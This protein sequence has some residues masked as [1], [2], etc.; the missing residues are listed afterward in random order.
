MPTT[1][2]IFLIIA[3][4]GTLGGLCYYLLSLW[5]AMRFARAADHAPK[6]AAFTPPISILKPLRGLDPQMMASFRSHCLQDYPEYEI[7]F[8]VGGAGMSGAGMSGASVSDTQ[9]DAATLEAVA[10]LQREFPEHAIRVVICDEVLGA[11]RKV[12]TL[13]QMLPHARY[14]HLLINDS[15]IRVD[16]DYLRRVFAPFDEISAGVATAPVGMVTTLYRGIAGNSLWAKVESLGISTDFAG[17]VLAAQMLEGGLRFGLGSTLAFTKAGLATIG[18]L[19]PIADYLGDDY[20]LG[21]RLHRAGY[22]IVLADAVVDTFLPHYSFAAFWQHQMR[23]ARNVRDVRRWGYLGVLLT[24]GLPWAILTFLTS[25][26]TPWM[27]A[28]GMLLGAVG[29]VRLMLAIALG[30]G[31][32]GDRQV[33]SLLWLVPLRDALAML[34][35]FASF[36]GNTIVWRGM[37]YRLKRGKLTAV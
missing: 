35:W 9:T 30:I 14:E 8:G 19:E 26:G 22:R 17:G 7:I 4:A 10:Q 2:A 33:A 21:A 27:P 31:I 12:S 37:R 34:T 5:S 32:L 29:F 28:M 20:E 3:L 24:F 16:R 6:V 23:W 25:L 15:D 1:Q 18:G 11:N 13:L 36:A